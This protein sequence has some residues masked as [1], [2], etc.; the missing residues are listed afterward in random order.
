[1][2][3]HFAESDG[4]FVLRKLTKQIFKFLF[5]ILGL[6]AIFKE[7][8]KKEFFELVRRTFLDQPFSRHSPFPGIAK[9]N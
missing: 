8:W 2:T 5:H 9:V 4:F 7:K 1:M 6:L 3:N